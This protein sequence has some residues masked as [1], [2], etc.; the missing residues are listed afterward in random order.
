[1]WFPFRTH[2]TR[3]FYNLMDVYFHMVFNPRMELADF[4]EVRGRFMFAGNN[5]R[6]ELLFKGQLY[7]ESLVN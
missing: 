3:D 4:L 6:G 5:P 1:M 2:I 7:D